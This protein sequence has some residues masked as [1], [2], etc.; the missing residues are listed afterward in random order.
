MEECPSVEEPST[1]KVQV[2]GSQDEQ[3]LRAQPRRHAV[4]TIP[5]STIPSH[6]VPSP[7]RS[8]GLGTGKQR[9]LLVQ[10]GNTAQYE[11]TAR[12]LSL[13]RLSLMEPVCQS[14]APKPSDNPHHPFLLLCR[15]RIFLKCSGWPGT[16]Y[17]AHRGLDAELVIWS[18]PLQHRDY[19]HRPCLASSCFFL[20]DLCLLSV[21]LFLLGPDGRVL[22]NGVS[23]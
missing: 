14:S 7:R 22:P 10:E 9:H 5:P 18:Q 23:I 17:A 3:H 11:L 8:S 16:R 15:G 21:S 12:V 1:P 4:T 20:N 2:Q 6:P 19:R 13:S